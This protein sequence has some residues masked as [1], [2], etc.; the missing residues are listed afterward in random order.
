MT[1]ICA[2]VTWAASNVFLAKDST[3]AIVIVVPSRRR[4]KF[5]PGASSTEPIDRASD[6]KAASTII[7]FILMKHFSVLLTAQNRL[8][9]CCYLLFAPT[10]L[11]GG[12][13]L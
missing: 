2:P 4:I 11:G 12:T 10:T 7:I 13:R 1:T 5:G 8:V 6:N 3:S 9:P